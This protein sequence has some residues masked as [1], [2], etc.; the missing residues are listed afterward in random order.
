ML[1]AHKYH[2]CFKK[3]LVNFKKRY[4]AAP[5]LFKKI[6]PTEANMFVFFHDVQALIVREVR[7][8]MK[9]Q[10]IDKIKVYPEQGEA[11]HPTLTTIRSDCNSS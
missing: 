7:K 4:N 3:D 9:E 5:L 8:K 2:K 6:E 1:K 11:D 10:K